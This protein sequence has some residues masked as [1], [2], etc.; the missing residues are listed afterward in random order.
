MLTC[1]FNEFSLW[2]KQRRGILCRIMIF[3]LFIIL[4]C[5]MNIPQVE[6]SAKTYPLTAGT[7]ST[8]N[9]KKYRKK[10]IKV[11]VV[12]ATK[13]KIKLKI[14]N[15][16]NKTYLYT[17][18]DLQIKKKS[19]G[20]WKKIYFKK[21]AL[22][23]KGLERVEPKTNKTV[24]IRWEEYFDKNNFKKGT[25]KIMWMSNCNFKIR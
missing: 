15:K 12:S 24:I 17:K 21:G 23:M 22:F 6:C 19:K 18:L 8:H 1:F 10:Y 25:Y 5:N 14:T 16:G 11:R 9:H 7:Y 4:F 20:K 13:N 2:Q 3:S